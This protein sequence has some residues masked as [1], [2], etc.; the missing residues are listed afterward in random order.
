MGERTKAHKALARNNATDETG[1][2]TQRKTAELTRRNSIANSAEL[3]DTYPKPA[4]RKKQRA[5]ATKNLGTHTKH[6]TIKQNNKARQITDAA[7]PEITDDESSDHKVGR[8]IVMC[9]DGYKVFR[10]T[11]EDEEDQEPTD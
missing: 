1:R 3:K 2:A 9:S 5:T 11:G 6:K 4:R 10:M 7:T 8:T